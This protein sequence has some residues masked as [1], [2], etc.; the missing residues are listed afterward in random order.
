MPQAVCD[1]DGQLAGNSSKKHIRFRSEMVTG[2][3]FGN[4]HVGFEMVNGALYNSP[5]FIEGDPFI[6]IPLDAGEHAE[7]HVFIRVRGTSFFAVLHGLLQSQT[8]C[9]F[10]IWTFG[11]INLTRSGRPFSWQC[12]AYFMSMELSFGQVG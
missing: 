5:Y 9:P 10:T 7:V 4:A 11:Q 1:N 12:L 3:P 8:H 2:F 6:G